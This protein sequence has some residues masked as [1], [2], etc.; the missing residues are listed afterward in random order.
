MSKDT[1]FKKG[2]S[3]NPN[4]RPKTPLVVK[5]IRAEM[6]TEVIEVIREQLTREELKECIRAVIDKIIKTGDV[7]SLN[8]LLNRSIG[9][10][11][12][13]VE[14]S[15]PNEQYRPLEHVTDEELD[16]M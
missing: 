15:G 10:V 4:G 1:K 16:A 14:H 9:K 5:Q 6:A 7:H 13:R 8:E 2:K 11:T 3:G 12:D